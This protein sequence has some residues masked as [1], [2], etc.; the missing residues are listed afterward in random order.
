M[1]TPTEISLQ[2]LVAIQ[3]KLQAEMPDL[4]TR[5]IVKTNS[6]AEAELS[7]MVGKEGS[8]FGEISINCSIPEDSYSSRLVETQ[9]SSSTWTERD[10]STTEAQDIASLLREEGDAPVI[11]VST[12]YRL[13]EQTKE[14]VASREVKVRFPP[15]GLEIDL[16]KEERINEHSIANALFE[17]LLSLRRIHEKLNTR[18]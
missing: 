14:I 1:S 4:T 11:V 9:V 10:L 3:S 18:K 2:L 13:G 16:N 15:K 12:L 7:L 17:D 8:T 6:E 5:P